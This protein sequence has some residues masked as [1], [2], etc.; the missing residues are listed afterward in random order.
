VF[1]LSEIIQSEHWSGQELLGIRRHATT[2]SVAAPWVASEAELALL[3]DHQHVS[4]T[5]FSGR[6]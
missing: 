4:A 2:S 6:P 3:F 1:V 5:V